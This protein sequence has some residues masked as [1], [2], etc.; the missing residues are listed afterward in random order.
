M[1]LYPIVLIWYY[2]NRDSIWNWAEKL[3][4]A[5]SRVGGSGVE[6]MTYLFSNYFDRLT[7]VGC[8][9]LLMLGVDKAN[10]LKTGFVFIL[11]MH[12]RNL[13]RNWFEDNRPLYTS[14]NLRMTQLICN[15]SFG[16]PSGHVEGT[17]TMNICIL[18]AC[19]LHSRTNTRTTKT[20]G[21]LVVALLQAL[22]IFS[23]MYTGR[24]H[25]VQG[26][27]SLLHSFFWMGFMAVCDPLWTKLCR[28]FLNGDKKAL[29]ALWS[30]AF[31]IYLT[32][33]ALWLLWLE[34]KLFAFKPKYLY[35]CHECF[36][37]NN[38]AMR[39]SMTKAFANAAVPLGIVSGLTV[40]GA[41]SL[42]RNDNIF[43][44]H[45]T[46]EGIGRF[47]FLFLLNILN[48]TSI[49]IKTSSIDSF[50]Y[51]TIFCFATNF[52]FVVLFPKITECLRIRFKGDLIY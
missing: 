37:N 51:S 31:G 42:E 13:L 9:A 28:G 38:Y 47:F 22:M 12:S 32:V 5:S 20:I 34:P 33:G 46:C 8:C 14:A 43:W 41:N 25:I 7:P 44:D 2:F 6:M 35:R 11:G 52:L 50:L 18:Y 39:I 23:M 15:C 27:I 19:I 3:C 29:I 1:I 16:I 10:A 26:S 21:V 4:D 36:K 30:M 40:T 48:F 49:P 45:M 17:A 24:H